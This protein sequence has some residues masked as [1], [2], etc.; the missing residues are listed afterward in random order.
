MPHQMQYLTGAKKGGFWKKRTPGFSSRPGFRQKK[1]AF[2][3][4][5]DFGIQIYGFLGRWHAP[6][7]PVFFLRFSQK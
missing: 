5:L 2:S 6:K 3:S 1:G 7:H 4:I